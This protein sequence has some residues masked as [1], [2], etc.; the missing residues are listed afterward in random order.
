MDWFRRLIF[1]IL[2]GVVGSSCATSAFSE[3]RGQG[4]APTTNEIHAGQFHLLAIG[5]DDY[6]HWPKLKTAANDAAEISKTLHDQYGFDEPQVV[7]LLDNQATRQR[8]IQS[9]RELA[10]TVGPDD[11]VLVF[12]AGHGNLD[13]VTGT[14]FWIPVE[15]DRDDQSTWI[16]NND[17]KSLVR[18]MKARHVLLVSDSCFAGDF[19]R[20]YR[21]GLPAI[22]DEYVRSA[23]GKLS[24]QAI[25]SGALEPVADEGSEGHSWF[26]YFLLRELR[27]NKSPYLLPSDLWNR[28]RGGIAANAR[29]EPLLG[30]LEAVGGE[31]GGEFVLFRKG[32]S[33][34]LDALIQQK[35]EQMTELEKADQAAKERVASDLA[36]EQEKQSELHQL[37]EQISRLQQNLAQQPTGTDNLRQLRAMV[38]EKEQ[39]E[40]ELSKL[41]AA[42]L[43]RRRAEFEEDYSYYLDIRRNTHS[44]PEVVQKAWET[45]CRKWD[46]HTVGSAPAELVWRGEQGPG[47]PQTD[48]QRRISLGQGVTIEV[49]YIPPG[50]FM[51]GSK[52]EYPDEKPAHRV[53]ITRGFWMGKYEVTQ[54][55][56]ETLMGNNPSKHKGKDYPVDSVSWNDAVA[57]C[58]RLSETSGESC[59]LPT[60]A[61]W[62]YACQY[63]TSFGWLKRVAW[64][65]ENSNGTTHPV[66]KKEP[67]QFG[68]YDMLGNVWEWC[69]DWYGQDYYQESPEVDPAGPSSGQWRVLRGGSF[70]DG[71]GNCRCANRGRSSP[72]SADAY[73]GFRV[74]LGGVR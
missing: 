43:A 50:G 73:D 44:S 41:K 38:S 26:T 65:S 52:D 33:G 54:L 21:G 14:G 68:L 72:V 30:T 1:A 48:E 28:I 47:I 66:G 9:L 3:D 5:I 11:S 60:E 15:A 61:E 58:Q 17:V 20:G 69:G 70:Y 22:T 2:A 27:E 25:T 57:F 36:L 71:P 34:T 8:I 6:Q 19:F 16:S 37:E 24:R 42:N 67:N 46:L 7:T 23:F 29:Q 32:L 35:K 55:Q 45:I 59:R 31:V 40:N 49:V 63:K 64:F 12:Y 74:V 18:A 51:M 62:E 4:V 39:R 13:D 53:Q 56:Y 10:K